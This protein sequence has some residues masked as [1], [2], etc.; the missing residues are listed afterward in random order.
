MKIIDTIPPM[1]EWSESERRHGRRIALIPTM[2]FLHEGHLSLVRDA[3][4][5]ADRVVVSIFVNPTQFAPNEDFA[6]YPRDLEKDRKLLSGEGIDILFN[7]SA[8]ELYP[9]DFQTAVDVK[10]MS[11]VLCGAHRPGHFRGVATVVAKLF[12]IV[13]PHVAVFGEKDYQQLQLIRRLAR[14]LNFGVEIVGCPTVRDPDGLAM[15]SRNAYLTRDERKAALC[16]SR[17]LHRAACLVKKGETAA[18]IIMDAA[19]AEIGSEPLARLE[20]ARLCDTET[21]AELDYV[22]DRV[23][24]ALA[25]YI[26]KTRLID[27]AV[28]E[29]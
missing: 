21:L 26:G 7:P 10:D 1:Q 16:L 23:L 11:G 18:P 20:Y 22:K 19:A 27:N 3:K 14:D 2:G 25:V 12:N 29:G 8:A 17:A 9:K 28:L 24:L 4:K 15:S 13:R 5:R 6:A